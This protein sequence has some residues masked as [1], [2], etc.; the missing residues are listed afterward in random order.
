MRMLKL[1]DSSLAS[2]RDLVVLSRRQ[3]ECLSWAE[4]GKSAR[5]TGQILGISQRTVEKHL[6]QA[7]ETLGVRTRIQAVVRARQL[8][9]LNEG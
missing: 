7:Y 5:D 8:G 9:L 6:E 4:A 3:I 2:K 1:E